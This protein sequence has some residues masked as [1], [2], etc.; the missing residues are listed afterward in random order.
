MTDTKIA[1]GLEDA[2]AYAKGDTSRG[3]LTRY[4]TESH[5]PVAWT[6]RQGDLA[7]FKSWVES[8]PQ[9]HPAD[10]YVLERIEQYQQKERER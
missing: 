9:Y 1:R 2:I 3:K 7:Q 8:H 10:A 6:E 5:R 4:R